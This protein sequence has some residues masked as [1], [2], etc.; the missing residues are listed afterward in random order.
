MDPRLWGKSG[1]WLLGE[2]MMQNTT[3]TL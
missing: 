1:G 2:K 3:M